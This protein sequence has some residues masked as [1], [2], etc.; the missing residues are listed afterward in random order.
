MSTDI[1][2]DTTIIDQDISSITYYTDEGGGAL[3]TLIPTFS[4]TITTSAVF[5]CGNT[6]YALTVTDTSISSVVTMTGTQY[7]TIQTSDYNLVG[8]Y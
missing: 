4:D 2:T 1:C 8:T 5:N 6:A 3:Q 7:I